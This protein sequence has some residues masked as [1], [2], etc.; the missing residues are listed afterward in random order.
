M[1]SLNSLYILKERTSIIYIMVIFS[2]NYIYTPHLLQNYIWWFW[3]FRIF[4]HLV[5]TNSLLFYGMLR[6][7]SVL[8]SHAVPALLHTQGSYQKS[9]KKFLDI[10]LTFPG[11]N[12]EIP[13]QIWR[14]NC[15]KVGTYMAIFWAKRVTS[16]TSY[17]RNELRA[18]R[19]TSKTSYEEREYKPAGGPRGAVSPREFFWI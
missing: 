1:R 6:K 3:K 14:Y 18:K 15:I 9:T 7:A 16:E 11:H 12:S 13:W 8:P 5:R 19:V 2:L 17:E 4:F 10:S